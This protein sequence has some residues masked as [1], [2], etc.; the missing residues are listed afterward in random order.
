MSTRALEIAK[1]NL[2]PSL[3]KKEMVKLPS[4]KKGSSNPEDLETED[5]ST[6]SKQ[7]PEKTESK[8]Y[9]Q[10]SLSRCLRKH[11]TTY[12]MNLYR[13]H[14]Y[15]QIEVLRFG[16]S[17]KIPNA[18]KHVQLSRKNTNLKTIFLDLDETLIHCD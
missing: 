16:K 15:Q 13:Q 7:F 12:L 8:T 6:K 10:S 3:R 4:I 14:F 5:S 18:R 2:L 9:Y 17:I 1:T 11:E